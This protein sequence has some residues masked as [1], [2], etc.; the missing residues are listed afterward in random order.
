MGE[1]TRDPILN[2]VAIL[3][4]IFYKQDLWR[5]TSRGKEP[6]SD[7]AS[8]PSILP[9]GL[10][11][12]LHMQPEPS[13]QYTPHTSTHLTPAYTSHQHTP[14]HTSHQE[15]LIPAHQHIPHTSIYLTQAHTSHQHKTHTSTHL[16][17]AHT[18]TYLTP[19]HTSTYLTLV[20]ISD[21]HTFS[22]QD[23]YYMLLHIPYNIGYYNM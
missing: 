14:A 15:N 23:T 5:K 6:S 1:I 11:P 4:F 7:R 13:H 17:P 8:N 2:S 21:Q 19:A 12:T 18:S 9:F 20:H 22:C 10:C 16:T 3:V